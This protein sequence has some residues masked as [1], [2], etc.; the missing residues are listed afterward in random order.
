MRFASVAL[1]IALGLAAPSLAQTAWRPG[2]SGLGV[3]QKEKSGPVQLASA[4]DLTLKAG[5]SQE[6]TLRFV[7]ADGL[8]INSHTPR[9]Q[10]MIPTAL[11]LEPSSGL[12]VV[13]IRYPPGVNYHFAFAPNDV[14]SVYTGQLAL[15]VRVKAAP[16]RHVLQGQLKYQACDQ[17]ACRPSEE[18]P[19][20]L[21]INAE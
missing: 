15:L 9:S 16:G 8:H 4:R 18:L 10:F 19:V 3:L 12:T 20:T 13:G 17:R 2:H 7:I 6:V 14:L 1:G 11:R 21:R 5:H